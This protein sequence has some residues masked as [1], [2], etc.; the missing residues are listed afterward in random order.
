MVVSGLVRSAG[1][2][3][4]ATFLVMVICSPSG[5]FRGSRG[6]RQGDPLSPYLFVIGMKALSCLIIKAMEGGFLSGFKFGGREGDGLIVS[7]LLYADDTILFFE[8]KQ[9]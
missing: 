2:F 6:L 9:D 4:L 1:V 3:F 7:H 5:F 8:S